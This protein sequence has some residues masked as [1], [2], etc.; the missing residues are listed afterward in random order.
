MADST[1]LTEAL[2]KLVQAPENNLRIVHGFVSKYTSIEGA[3][4]TIDFISIDGTVRIKDIPLNAVP[5]LKKGQMFIP[6]LKSDITILWLVGTGDAS[7]LSFSHLDT[8]NIIATNEINIGVVGEKNNQDADYDEQENNGNQT[9]TKYTSESITST[10]SNKNDTATQTLTP[11]NYTSEIGDSKTEQNKTEIKQ[12]VG[13]SY[14]Q[15]SSNDITLEGGQ[16]YL[17]EGATEP[18]VLGQQLVTLMMKFMTECSKITTPT[19]LGTMPIINLGNFLSFLSEC[20][21]FLSQ[22]VKVK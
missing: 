21:S 15:I 10:A 19:M 4:G 7:I 3:L 12:S 6:C 17:G 9:N 8:Q 13:N 5:G 20:N 2:R 11:T 16:I 1:K 18:A 22:T 14:E